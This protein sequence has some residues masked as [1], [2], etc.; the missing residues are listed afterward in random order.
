MHDDYSLSDVLER[1]PEVGENVRGALQ[2]IS[3]NAGHIK[4]GLAT[5]KRLDIG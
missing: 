4:Q 3:E 2:T 5:L 1:M